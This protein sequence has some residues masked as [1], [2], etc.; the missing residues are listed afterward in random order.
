M[1]VVKIDPMFLRHANKPF[2]TIF[3]AVLQHITDGFTLGLYCYLSSLPPDWN[4]NSVHLQ[5]HFGVGSR[6]L[7]QSM[8][9]L[10]KNNLIRYIQEKDEK[11]LWIKSYIEVQDGL[12]FIKN[13]DNNQ[14]D[15]SGG[16]KTAPPVSSAGSKTARPVFRTP[17][18]CTHTNKTNNKNKTNL[19]RAKNKRPLSEIFEADK[20]NRELCERLRLNMDEE[21]KSFE[22][23]HQGEKNQY[24]F[25]RWM[26][27][28]FDYKNRKKLTTIF[29]NNNESRQT[30]KFWGP[31]HE[32]YDSIHNVAG[33][34][35]N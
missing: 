1:S 22:N 8:A 15:E 5:K 27:S 6:K 13:I 33:R 9:W 29:I 7:K 16:S 26:K 19:E 4:V 21:L 12:Q 14:K 34:N 20:S 24:E 23:R 18:K 35:K 3:N 17:R 32:G 25:E 31:G 30:A 28:S 11:G 10:S 2:T